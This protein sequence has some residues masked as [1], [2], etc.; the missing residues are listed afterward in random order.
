MLDVFGFKITKCD[1]YVILW[2]LY[3]AQGLLNFTGTLFSQ[4]L[5]GCIFIWSFCD[6]MLMIPVYQNRY[7]KGLKIYVF[8]LFILGVI[9]IVKDD[10]IKY[11][12]G[13]KNGV[14]LPNWF[15]LK[16]WGMQWLSLFTFYRFSLNGSLN[17][18]RLKKYTFIFVGMALV[19]FIGYQ[20]NYNIQ[21]GMSSKS[22]GDITNNAGYEFLGLLPY[23]FLWKNKIVQ[24]SL[25]AFLFIFILLSMKRG[26][27]IIG[28]LVIFW[29]MYHNLKSAE[30][31]ERLYLL[32]FT[33]LVIILGI[34][35]TLDLY[36]SNPYMQRRVLATQNNDSSDRDI[37]YSKM[38]NYLI[39]D[40][41]IYYKMFGGG[42]CYTVK[43]NG[44][45]AHNDWLEIL[46]CGGLM[47]FSLFVNYW[48]CFLKQ[49]VYAKNYKVCYN[50][51]GVCLFITFVQ[52]FFSMSTI[53]IPMSAIMTYSMFATENDMD[54]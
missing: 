19:S 36:E 21:Y 6:F 28:F 27:I 16:D 3:N 5:L 14:I 53:T 20:K 9:L 46:V 42:A 7:F 35:Y 24:Y 41:D 49:L 25:L 15:Y 17:E 40:A 30:R 39:D 22:F 37:I 8:Y 34:Y 4:L 38:L 23:L 44:I 54:Y 11:H 47:G 33:F 10:V 29:L 52:T 12:D 48:C 51:I 45:Q 50:I 13:Y 18:E 32:C 43:I 26:V 2:F 1:L 31:K